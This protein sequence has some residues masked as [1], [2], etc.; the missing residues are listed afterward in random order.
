MT[1]RI[2]QP[3]FPKRSSTVETGGNSHASFCSIQPLRYIREMV[4]SH[5]LKQS[6]DKQ[7]QRNK[8]LKIE[9]ARVSPGLFQHYSSR[10]FLLFSSKGLQDCIKEDF[11]SVLCWFEHRLLCLL[12]SSWNRSLHVSLTFALTTM[13]SSCWAD[14][15]AIQI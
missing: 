9:R 10:H 1:S 14:S 6:P 5:S 4:A 11:F 13:M 7:W 12:V 15:L 3:P 2:F 8:L